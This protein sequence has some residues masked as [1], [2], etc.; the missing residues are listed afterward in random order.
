MNPP[1]QIIAAFTLAVSA[2]TVPI[3][4]I[5]ETDKPCIAQ[6]VQNPTNGS[7]WM[8][9][10]QPTS[11][12]VEELT[13]SHERQLVDRS[14]PASLR[15]HARAVSFYWYQPVGDTYRLDLNNPT[16]A[17]GGIARF[18]GQTQQSKTV[19]SPE[20]ASIASYS[21]EVDHFIKLNRK[22]V[23]GDISSGSSDQASRWKEFK[24]EAAREKAQT[25]DNLNE[26]A[27]V[28]TRSG[29]VIGANFTFTSPSGDWAHYVMY[30]F[31]EGGS[32]ARIK[33][34]LNT[35]YGDVSI[36]RDRFYSAEGK[37]LKSTRKVLDLKTQKPTKPP[38]D[39]FDEEFPIFRKIAELPF[40]KLL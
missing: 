25:G 13:E 33:A 38:K 8:V 40:H 37:L 2:G 17:V 7:W 31:R 19:P 22:R 30:Y 11:G 23:F 14:S 21:A 29:K 3:Q 39:F 32:L 6:E 26:N 35:F 4:A 9:Q 27:F 36:V 15:P 20:L 12:V 24:S 1:R 18:L 5:A 10:I 28:W 34:Q 16:T